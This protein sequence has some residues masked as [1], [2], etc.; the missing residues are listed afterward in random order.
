MYIKFFL[1]SLLRLLG[2]IAMEKDRYVCVCVCVR[3]CASVCVCVRVCVRAYVCVRKCWC[4][5][6]SFEY[7]C[8]FTYYQKFEVDQNKM[9]SRSLGATLLVLKA[10]GV[11]GWLRLVGSLKL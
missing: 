10:H 3:A 7:V 5:I 11:M 9:I 1:D 6:L 4:I 2:C 8:C